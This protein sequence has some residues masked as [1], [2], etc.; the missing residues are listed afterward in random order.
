VIWEADDLRLLFC[1][2]GFWGRCNACRR[3]RASPRSAEARSRLPPLRRRPG[4]PRSALPAP[5]ARAA[6]RGRQHRLAGGGQPRA[7]GPGGRRG[8]GRGA[9]GRGA[10]GRG[11]G[12]RRGRRAAADKHGGGGEARQRGQRLVRA[13]GQGAAPL[14]AAS[15]SFFK[16]HLLAGGSP[17]LEG[18]AFQRPCGRQRRPA[19]RRRPLPRPPSPACPPHPSPIRRQVYDATPFLADHPGG[20]ES[21]LI[22]AGADATDEFNGIHSGK[23]KAMLV[24]YYIGDLATAEEVRGMRF[25]RVCVCVCVRARVCAC[26]LCVCG[27]SVS[28]CVRVCVCV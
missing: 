4:Q 10:Q 27:V 17:R 20:A 23:A 7:P 19:P 18:A 28:V 1:V 12:G 26:W 2:R 13:R 21:I 14:G 3:W 6:R 15:T 24:D 25:V 5:G 11:G 8:R 16:L 9:A 22:S